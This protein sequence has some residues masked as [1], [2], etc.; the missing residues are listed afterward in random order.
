MELKDLRTELDETDGEILRLFQRRMGIVKEIAAYKKET[1]A[2]IHHPAREREILARVFEQAETDLKSYS[3]VL[4][5][6]LLDLSR[7]YQARQLIHG[8]GALSGRIRKALADT[9][10]LFPQSGVVACQG[11]EG[12]YSQQACDRLFPTAS[13]LYFKSFE[14]VFNAVAQGL[15]QYGMLPIENSTNGTVNAVYDLMRRYDFHIVRSVKLKIKP[16]SSCQAR[17][18]VLRHPG[19]CLARAGDRPVLAVF[20]PEQRK[21]KPPSAKIPRRRPCR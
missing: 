4:F 2:P 13:I 18:E 11:V 12:A 8:D 19:N 17:D 6:T 21:S 1:G 15:C 3:K 16:R 20:I 7:S 10:K 14:G 9:P 5:S